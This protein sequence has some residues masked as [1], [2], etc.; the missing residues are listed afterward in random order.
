[1]TVQEKFLSRGAKCLT[2]TLLL[3][4]HP[5]MAQAEVVVEEEQEEV[6]AVL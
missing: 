3:P 5:A 1:M 6:V 4:L 2:S